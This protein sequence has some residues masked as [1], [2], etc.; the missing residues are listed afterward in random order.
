MA[1]SNQRRIEYM[2]LEH[3][4]P[5]ARN[6]KR[7]ADDAIAASI[8]RFGYVEP[9]VLD[10]RTGRLV[11]GH[12]RLESLRAAADRGDAPPDGIRA[13]RGGWAV[14]VLRGWAS[15]D[16]AHAEAY[17]AASN[18]LVELGGW[19][20]TELAALLAGV[21]AVDADLADIAGWN[22]QQ[23]ADLLATVQD[24]PQART[25]P[26][27]APATPAGA[28]VTRPRDVW[29]LGP[30]R[31]VCGDSTEPATFAAL[32]GDERAVM[33]WTD[34][35]Y[36]VEYVGKTADALTIPTM[37]PVELI[38]RALENSSMGGHCA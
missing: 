25:E 15:V 26:D 27:D 36:G 9:I 16:D 3:L 29:D 12:G 4:Q 14:P 20:D 28:P 30:H 2:P 34:P 31:L 17:L 11:A 22:D 5:A 38:T 13:A 6:P 24:A 35:P 23:L 33:V 32:L 18:R 7:H 8:D 19:D 21:T 10:E 1:T 37:K